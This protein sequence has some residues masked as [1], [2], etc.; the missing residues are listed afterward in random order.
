MSLGQKLINRTGALARK[1]KRNPIINFE[2]VNEQ[3]NTLKSSNGA[4]KLVL[5]SQRFTDPNFGLAVLAQKIEVSRV[6]A[7]DISLANVSGHLQATINNIGTAEAVQY[8]AYADAP[9][10]IYQVSTIQT[11][12]DNDG[13]LNNKY[14]LITTANNEVLYYIWFN[15]GGNGVDPTVAYATGVP[16]NIYTNSSASVVATALAAA[17]TAVNGGANWSASATGSSVTITY[18]SVG[19][20]NLPTDGYAALSTAAASAYY[21]VPASLNRGTGFSYAITTLGQNPL[22]LASKYFVINDFAGTVAVWYDV[23]GV[24]TAPVGYN[25]TIE[26][27]VA[28]LASASTVA[29]ATAAAL[30]ADSQFTSASQGALFTAVNKTIGYPGAPSAGTSTFPVVQLQ[31]GSDNMSNLLQLNPGDLMEVLSGELLGQFFTIA[32]INNNVVTMT[33][34]APSET[35]ETGISARFEMRTTI[36]AIDY[37]PSEQV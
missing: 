8:T 14:F 13:T 16:V 30:A 11:V 2:N 17:L 26:V 31:Q 34:E 29:A 20:A 21:V 33:T 10:G 7:Q 5:S 18:Q 23:G 36:P 27:M 3:M 24:G 4:Q 35:G 15:V 28:S 9:S 6:V 1:I 12:A 22:S 37:T 32:S 19:P 25:R